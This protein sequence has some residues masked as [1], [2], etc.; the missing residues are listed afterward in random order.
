MP[1]R[2]LKGQVPSAKWNVSK[3]CPEAGCYEEAAPRN[4]SLGRKYFAAS[5]FV[6]LRSVPVCRPP[7]SVPFCKSPLRPVSVTLHNTPKILSNEDVTAKR[8][9]HLR[10]LN[11]AT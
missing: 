1:K 6:D 5:L 8:R 4:V 9:R 3:E 2:C 7:H 10:I 11:G